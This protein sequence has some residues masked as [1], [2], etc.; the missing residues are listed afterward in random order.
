MTDLVCSIILLIELLTL[1]FCNVSVIDLYVSFLL[2]IYLTVGGDSS[3][4]TECEI[5]F[6]RVCFREQSY[7]YK[8]ITRFRFFLCSTELV[9]VD[10]FATFMLVSILS[11]E[12]SFDTYSQE[13]TASVPISCLKV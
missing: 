12:S 10:L 11:L 7:F 2:I 6:A 5:D 4:I 1:D 3:E 9:F 13:F 8:L